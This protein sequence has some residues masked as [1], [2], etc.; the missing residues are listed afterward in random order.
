MCRNQ[1]R[2]SLCGGGC[3]DDDDGD[4]SRQRHTHVHKSYGWVE[5]DGATRAES[6]WS[7]QLFAALSD[8][9]NDDRDVN[10]CVN[11]VL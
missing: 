6:R 1:F 7:Y 3:G 4:T 8:D 2:H 9:D 11:T 10:T 5:I